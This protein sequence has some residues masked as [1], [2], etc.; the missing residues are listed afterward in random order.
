MPEFSTYTIIPEQ[1]VCNRNT[2]ASPS[3]FCLT[4]YNPCVVCLSVSV[5]L[6]L[7]PYL[8]IVSSMRYHEFDNAVPGGYFAHGDV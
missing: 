3:E 8:E 2:V 5:R 7:R 6:R 1:S 4:D